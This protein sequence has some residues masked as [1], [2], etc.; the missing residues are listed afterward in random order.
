MTAPVDP[1][2]IQALDDK[3]R[4]LEDLLA[5]EQ[6]EVSD[7]AFLACQ[8]EQKQHYVHALY[9]TLCKEHRALVGSDD[10]DDQ[11]TSIA[12]TALDATLRPV[13]P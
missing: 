2:C 12:L 11:A 4:E 3:V 7:I 9:A 6:A 5:V 1:A 10:A 13:F 8:V